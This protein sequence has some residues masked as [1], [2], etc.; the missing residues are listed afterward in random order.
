MLHNL[1]EKKIINVNGYEA[2]YYPSH[3][4]AMSNGLVYLHRLVYENYINSILDTSI[5]I[6]HID[7]NKKNNSLDNLKPIL[8]GQ[9]MK[10][11]I[12]HM[13]TVRML[14]NKTCSICNKT[15]KT[16]RKSQ[17]FCSLSCCGRYK[18]IANYPNKDELAEEIKK[19]SREEIGRRYGVTGNAVKR[20]CI[21]YGFI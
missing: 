11:H 3:P 7:E 8:P 21:K 10:I 16:Y 13:N 9:H 12:K 18:R 2:V 14:Y 4:N 15:I 5:H 19:F 20:W 1:K 6:H 17:K